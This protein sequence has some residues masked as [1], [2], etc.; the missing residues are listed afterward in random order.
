MNLKNQVR[1]GLLSAVSGFLSPLLLSASFAPASAPVT[2]QPDHCVSGW[3]SAI[4][5]TCFC[6]QTAFAITL[7]APNCGL[8]GENC[9]GS[10]LWEVCG[11]AGQ[12]GIHFLFCEDDTF[13]NVRC[14]FGGLAST[15][16][17]T[18][19]PCDM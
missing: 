8:G 17:I 11:K 7:D 12:S 9:E 6:V 3:T 14:P 5:S 4:Y 16:T 19:T 2:Q 13:V 1:L 18:C 10:A 15:V